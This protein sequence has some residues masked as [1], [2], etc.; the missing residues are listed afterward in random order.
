MDRKNARPD[1]AVRR[2]H[3]GYILCSYCNARIAELKVQPADKLN[4]VT[5]CVHLDARFV[6][7]SDG[8]YSL[9]SH[10]WKGSRQL[11]RLHKVISWVKTESKE[12]YGA[13]QAKRLPL[14]LPAEVRCS[15]CSE[16]Q[17]LDPDLLKVAVEDYQ[18]PSDVG[19]DKRSIEDDIAFWLSFWEK[20]RGKPTTQEQATIEAWVR[21]EF[22][23]ELDDSRYGMLLTARAQ[24]WIKLKNMDNQQKH[25]DELGKTG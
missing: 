10:Q 3:S 17:V 22:A 25:K 7:G 8:V 4:P 23:K 1:R 20:H 24:Q 6:L 13:L 9:T 15:Q 14:T 5:H 12:E 19:G 18:M 11:R 2:G 21:S 16:I